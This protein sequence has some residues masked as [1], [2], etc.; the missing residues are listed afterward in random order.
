MEQ[1][2]SSLPTLL[3]R[4]KALVRRLVEIERELAEVDRQILAAGRASAPTPR[5][6]HQRTATPA[7]PPVL[8]DGIRETVR[9]LREVGELA[10][11]EVAARLTITPKL[12]SYRLT[13]AQRLGLVER[14]GK[15]R[16]RVVDES[17]S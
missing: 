16:Y 3:Q 11:R 2:L 17:E 12:A 15:A 8:R 14:R 6:P 10:P 9:L 7:E 4:S 5:G 13:Q 1:P